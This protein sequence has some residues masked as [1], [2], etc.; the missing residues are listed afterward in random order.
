MSAGRMIVERRARGTGAGRVGWR[1]RHAQPR[2]VGHQQRPREQAGGARKRARHGDSRREQRGGHHEAEAQAMRPKEDWRP[3]KVEDHLDSNWCTLASVFSQWM[4]K[5][6]LRDAE[7][8][9]WPFEVALLQ[10][11]TILWT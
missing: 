3:R 5:A 4:P 1:G 7:I 9:V 8:H 2:Q 6:G 11:L 10:E